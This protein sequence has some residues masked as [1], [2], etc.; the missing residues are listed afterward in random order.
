MAGWNNAQGSAII[1][2][3]SAIYM[4]DIELEKFATQ[5]YR[6]M[7]YHAEHNGETGDHGVDVMLMNLKNQKEIVQCKQWNKPIG[8]PVIRDLYGAMIHEKAIRA[9]VWAPRGFSQPAKSWAKGKPIELVDDEKIGQLVELAY[10]N[11]K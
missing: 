1:Q 7:G 6:K 4:S 2:K 9:W 8:E 5:V 10:T 3:Q 11:K